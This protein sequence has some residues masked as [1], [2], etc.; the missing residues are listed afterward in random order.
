[1]YGLAGGRD[2]NTWLLQRGTGRCG[3]VLK[4][5]VIERGGHCGEVAVS[6]GSTVLL[7]LL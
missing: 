2:K 4:M 6:R 3:E 5:A 1:M 7:L